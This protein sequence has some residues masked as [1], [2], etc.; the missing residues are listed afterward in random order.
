MGMEA[1]AIVAGVL[2]PADIR[3][4]L[5][6]GRGLRIPLGETVTMPVA[7]AAARSLRIALRPDVAVF[8][9]SSGGGPMLTV[10]QLVSDSDAATVR[11]ALESLVAEF[12]LVANALVAQMGTYSSPLSGPDT[13]CPESVRYD[14]ATW[15]LHPHGEHCQ[16]E[17]AASGEVV[18]TNIYAPDVV[19]PYFLLQYAKTSGRHSAVVDACVEGFHDMCRL[20]DRAGIP[21]G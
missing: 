10:L 21:Y 15:Y 14:D 12:R 6:R 16:F 5:A 2:D 7:A 8:A 11:P 9:S 18:E 13:E 4:R 17:N 1:G 20:L 3:P 19:D